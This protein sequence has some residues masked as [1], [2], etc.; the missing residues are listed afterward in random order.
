ME[1]GRILYVSYHRLIDL[2]SK[3]VYIS[4]LQHSYI[5]GFKKLSRHCDHNERE[6][7]FISFNR[8]SVSVQNRTV[9][10]RKPFSYPAFLSFIFSKY[11]KHFIAAD[12][13][14]HRGIC[15]ASVFPCV[16]CGEIS[17]HFVHILITLL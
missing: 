6:R 15:K 7:R 17:I 4:V 9:N 3:I 5:Y 2:T 16:L 12:T 10:Y 1:S 13:A 8:H 14:H 11:K